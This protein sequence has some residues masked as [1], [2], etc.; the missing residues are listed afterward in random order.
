MYGR[1]GWWVEMRS[2]GRDGGMEVPLKCAL[3]N[4]P[5]IARLTIAGHGERH[6]VTGSVGDKDS[7]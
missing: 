3:S 7:N 5:S 4:V 6:Q 2:K 1:K